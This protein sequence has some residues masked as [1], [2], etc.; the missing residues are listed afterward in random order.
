MSDESISLLLRAISNSDSQATAAWRQ[1]RDSVD[2]QH[3]TWTEMQMLAILNGPR[4]DAWLTNDAESGILRGILRRA[5]SEAQIR[6]ALAREVAEALALAGCESVTHIGAVG[7]YLRNFDSPS[8]R[9]ILEIRLLIPRGELAIAAKALRA[10]G[11]QSDFEVPTGEDL[12]WNTSMYF[13]RNGAGLFL[14]WG[15]LRVRAD[16][17]IA[18]E[19]EFLSEYRIVEAIGTRFQLLT[20]EHALLEAL[21][22]KDTSVDVVP[23]QADAALL[24]RGP[25]DWD[26]WAAL[27]AAFQRT[28]FE[29]IP[30]LQAMG[31]AIPELRI[32]PIEVAPV[33]PTEL[34]LLVRAVRAGKHSA[35]RWARRISATLVRD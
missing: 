18:C 33:V 22:E 28:A 1:W 10:Q 25:I 15:V 27:A 31:F 16:R 4:F 3:L 26:R 8:I 34:S 19:E 24:L 12:D 6:L 14:H 13:S 21:S 35:H 20:P 23:W 17:A 11:W 9:P 2:I 29:R 5:W 32:P 7:A 30:E